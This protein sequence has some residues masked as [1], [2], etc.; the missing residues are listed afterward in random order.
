MQGN[1][2][3][4]VG[5]GGNVTVQTGDDGILLVDSGLPANADKLLAEVRK[6]SKGPIRYLINTHVHPDHVGGNEKIFLAGSTITGGNVTGD[7]QDAGVGAT[8]IAHEAVLNR[9]SAATGNQAMPAKA[10]PSDTYFTKE[11]K[12]FF[13][14]EA[15]LIMHVPAAHTDGDTM[16]YFRRS[17]VIS[18]GDLYVTTSYPIVDLQRGGNIQGILEALNRMIDISVPADKQEGGTYIIPGHGRVADQADLVEYRDMVTIIRDRIARRRQERPHP[19][20][21][22]GRAAHARLRRGLQQARRLLDRRP[23]HRSRLQK[24]EREKVGTPIM[25]NE[26]KSR[27]AAVLLAAGSFA[28]PRVAMAQPPPA[29]PP[30]RLSAKDAA[31]EDITGYWV[32]IVTEDW[33]WRMLTPAKGDITS[34]PLNP[35]G[36]KTAEAWDPAKD[37]A[38]GRISAKPTALPASCACPRVCTSPGRTTTL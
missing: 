14:G 21:G 18:A 29:G 30:P 12:L 28:L 31:P 1:V 7:I 17:D 20:T 9:M 16:V 4:I 32:S 25:S 5:A 27:I 10:W 38:A 2:Y 22:E 33:R 37:E 13:N 8:I 3:M 19:R 35:V 26:T 15:V 11:K 34:I 36:R 24:P 6:L 23:V